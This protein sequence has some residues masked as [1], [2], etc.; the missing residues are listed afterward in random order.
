M[1]KLNKKTLELVNRAKRTAVGRTLCRLAGEETG[2]VM[3]EYVM[4]VVLIGVAC[5]AA[6][7]FL[8]QTARDEMTVAMN[9]ISGKID[10]ALELQEKIQEEAV[11][12]RKMIL[13]E[14]GSRV[15]KMAE[16]RD[17]DV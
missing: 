4:V 3:M 8:G 10:A 16:E 6:T 5:V 7:W 9:G 15:I 17:T 12:V 2:A 11:E 1:N 13:Q 14:K